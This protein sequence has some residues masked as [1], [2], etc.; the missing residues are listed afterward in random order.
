MG[1]RRLRDKFVDKVIEYLDEF[2]PA[3][4]ESKYFTECKPR[5]ICGNTGVKIMGLGYVCNFSDETFY[6][7]DTFSRAEITFNFHTDN[8]KSTNWSDFIVSFNSKLKL[9]TSPPI[10]RDVMKWERYES[11]DEYTGRLKLADEEIDSEIGLWDGLEKT[12]NKT[13]TS[14]LSQ[15]KIKSELKVMDARLLEN[16]S[17]SDWE[18][19]SDMSENDLTDFDIHGLNIKNL[20]EVDVKE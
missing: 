10:H 14:V 20:N 1:N 16:L 9:P 2:F 7:N 5:P 13:C 15:H 19:I 4:I 8:S 6:V 3:S 18:E 17:P 12:V 11:E